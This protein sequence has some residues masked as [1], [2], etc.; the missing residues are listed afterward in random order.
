MAEALLER[1]RTLGPQIDAKAAADLTATEI[2][3][4]IIAELIALG[5]FGM[6]APR[7]LGGGECHPAAII[8]VVRELA[9]WDGST[10]WY[11]GAT[12]VGEAVSGAFLGPQAA[13]AMYAGG[14]PRIAGQAAPG[15]NAVRQGDHFRV[16][17][18]FSF[19]TGCPTA[20]WIVG[21]YLVEGELDALGQPLFLLGMVPRDTV[22]FK[23][24]WQVLGLRGTGSYDVE[25]AEQLVHQDFF[26]QPFAAPQ[27][28]GGAFYRM[29]FMAPPCIAHSAFAL[30]VARRA[31][32][33]WRA[34]AR[35]KERLPGIKACDT[36]SFQR[37]FAAAEAEL[38]AAEAYVRRTF[39][40]LFAA[41]EAGPPPDDLRIDGRLAACHAFSTGRRVAQ[42]AFTAFATTGLRDGHAIQRCFRDM[43]AGNAHFLTGEA[44]LIDAGKALVGADGAQIAF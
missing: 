8:D 7:E 33:E 19:A 3:K 44:A 17:G 27:L 4:A 38:R 10:G 12:I 18:K 40:L 28:R 24:N 1:V 41:A 29:G 34:H 35:V 9:Y 2:D 37:D 43:Q 32:D 6:M 14:I 20:N 30:G 22:K 16:S 11:V 15:G 5:V 25:V 39:D 13:A 36:H 23:G 21:G 42:T 26:F 31:L